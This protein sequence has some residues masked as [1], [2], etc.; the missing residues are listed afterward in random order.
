VSIPSGPAL[1]LCA[2]WDFGLG[3]VDFG[4]PV[5]G[6]QLQFDIVKR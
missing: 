4:L 3:I 6:G 5:V 1:F 2:V